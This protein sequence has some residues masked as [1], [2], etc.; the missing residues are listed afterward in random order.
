MTM[1]GVVQQATWNGKI[2]GVWQS[3]MGGSP[4][5]PF[6][7][8]NHFAGWMLMALPLVLG[9]FAAQV[10]RGMAGEKPGLRNRVLW[11]ASPEA[12]Q[13]ILVGFDAIA[14]RFA[15]ADAAH[16]S[17]RGPIWQD[18]WR[19]VSDFFPFGTG[20]NTYGYATLFYQVT[21]PTEHLAEAHN[22]YLQLA[23]EGGLLL[24]VPVA[25]AIGLFVRDV[26]RRFAVGEREGTGYW[27]RVG[28]V[29]GLVA[30]AV[31]SL[32]DFSLQMP[33]NA[34]LFAVVA[35]VALHQ[36]G[37]RRDPGQSQG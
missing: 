23:A 33:G 17:G 2:Y 11:F 36:T 25:I 7:N 18:T 8:D 6:V 32:S 12:N 20:L 13:T 1:V 27:V 4:F 30:I 14:T 15:A 22:D 28:A 29:T 10:S 3:E 26:R 34:A 35:G 9:L 19:I 37:R 5:G 16:F 31:Q 21:M 24:G